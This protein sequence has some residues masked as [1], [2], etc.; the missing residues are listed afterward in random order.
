MSI[1]IVNRGLLCSMILLAS[2]LA[3][4]HESGHGLSGTAFANIAHWLFAHQGL[5]F[6]TT[7]LL[8]GMSI[9]AFST[10]K[11]EEK[12]AQNVEPQAGRN[13]RH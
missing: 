8:I 6:L 1:N 4:A 7:A 3:W 9:K 12:M 5:I 11:N 13:H 2:P 10:K